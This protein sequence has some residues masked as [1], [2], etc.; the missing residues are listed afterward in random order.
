MGPPNLYLIITFVSN[1]FQYNVNV[2]LFGA[3]L[4]Q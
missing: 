3:K 4:Q 1:N 2:K